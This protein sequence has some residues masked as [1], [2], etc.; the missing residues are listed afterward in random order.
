M[1]KH[2]I[3]G[4]NVYEQEAGVW[5]NH[6]IMFNNGKY[7]FS[8]EYIGRYY[9]DICHVKC[10]VTKNGQPFETNRN[11]YSELDISFVNWCMSDVE[12]LTRLYDHQISGQIPLF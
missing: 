10:I 3:N 7:K 12:H 8:F 9:R 11:T 5:N 2:E 4:I 1:K 6:K